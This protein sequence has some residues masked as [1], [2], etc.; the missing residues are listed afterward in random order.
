MR[1]VRR[2]FGQGMVEF[3]LILPLI[4]LIILAFIEL[5]RIVY[6]KTAL[7]DAVREGARYA[8]IQQNPCTSAARRAEIRQK[9]LDYAVGVPLTAAAVTV[10]CDTSVVDKYKVTVGAFST[11]TPMLPFMAPMLGAAGTLNV[12]STMQMTPYGVRP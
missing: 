1:Q 4:L 3:A 7:Y 8:I 6:F 2:D 5:A 9:V 12:K 11:V 10:T